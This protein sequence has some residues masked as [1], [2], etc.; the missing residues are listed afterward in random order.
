M[1]YFD[2]TNML[3]VWLSGGRHSWKSERFDRLVKEGGQIT[4][5]PRQR[6]DMMKEA[7][8]ILVEDAP[9][10]FVYHQLVG[11]LHKPYRKGEHMAKNKFGYDG[12]QWPGEG[13][14]TPYF[15]TLYIGK[16]VTTLRK[17]TFTPK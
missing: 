8:R 17:S 11:Q 15:N 3:G 6:S 10:I 7:E 5:N 4:D 9:G 12:V 13:T 2:A 16:E 1:D 14:A